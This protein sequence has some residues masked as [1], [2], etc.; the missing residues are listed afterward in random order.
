MGPTRASESDSLVK[1]LTAFICLAFAAL[2]CGQAP[3]APDALGAP[4]VID[5]P[6]PPAQEVD[7][8]DRTQGG[9]F[10]WGPGPDGR[11]TVIAVEGVPVPDH[12][13]QDEITRV[14]AKREGIDFEALKAQISA[15][16][17]AFAEK[18]R[19]GD[20]AGM[21]TDF[22]VGATPPHF[23]ESLIASRIETKS[24]SVHHPTYLYGMSGLGADLSPSG[25][26]PHRMTGCTCGGPG[27]LIAS[28]GH[29]IWDCNHVDSGSHTSSVCL[30]PKTKNITYS[31]G[32]ASIW[33]DFL[34]YFRARM[35]LAIANWA[36]FSSPTAT[37]FTFTDVGASG[38]NTATIAVYPVFGTNIL[39]HTQFYGTFED[40]GDL[41]FMNPGGNNHTAKAL[42]YDTIGLELDTANIESAS[43][44]SGNF[45]QRG[46]IDFTN[47][48]ENVMT[49]ELGHAMSLVHYTNQNPANI[50]ELG[51]VLASA[52]ALKPIGL[53]GIRP[54]TSVFWTALKF[55]NVNSTAN[56][57]S[58]TQQPDPRPL[59]ASSTGG[60]PNA[61]IGDGP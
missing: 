32:D 48:Y 35:N 14:M 22:T 34:S 1:H 31:L 59:D 41:P 10:E 57:E 11:D 37:G 54:N 40:E 19:A 43:I 7:H 30:F 45:A 24:S 28:A 6:N 53:G 44:A 23:L 49:H 17:K 13:D 60:Q 42:G 36:S 18:M 46:V 29:N 4:V 61:D 51:N 12:V 33:G 27:G 16:S 55:L 47:A 26:E 58:S 38:F 39:G 56:H 8:T 15:S 3:S 5:D 52:G 50:M 25:N 21:D 9:L 2:A 20:T